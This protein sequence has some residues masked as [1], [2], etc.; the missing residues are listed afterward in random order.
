MSEPYTIKDMVWDL[1]RVADAGCLLDPR[2][3]TAAREALR[4]IQ[5]CRFYC[6]DTSSDSTVEFVMK[7]ETV[8]SNYYEGDN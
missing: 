1:N 3:T 5:A 6:E 8:L 2:A 4:V 7:I